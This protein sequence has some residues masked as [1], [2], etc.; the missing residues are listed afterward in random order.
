[1]PVRPPRSLSARAQAAASNPLAMLEREMV[2]EAAATLGAVGRRLE[3]A[4][5]ALE[6]CDAEAGAAEADRAALVA[7]AGETL[8][9]YLVQ[10]EACGLRDSEAVMRLFRIPPEVQRRM[11]IVRSS[12]KR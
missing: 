8:W 12:N 4:L 6:R 10:R 9:R 1:M 11:G 7:A 5:V 2:Q 3:A